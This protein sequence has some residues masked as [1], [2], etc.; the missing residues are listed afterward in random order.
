MQ[1]K[2]REEDRIWYEILEKTKNEY[3]IDYQPCVGVT[4][5]RSTAEKLLS[6][7]AIRQTHREKDGNLFWEGL[8]GRELVEYDLI[9]GWLLPQV[10]DEEKRAQ[11]E[12]RMRVIRREGPYDYPE[13]FGPYS[14]PVK[15]PS[16]TMDYCEKAGNGIF[17]V[18]DGKHWAWAIHNMVV[19]TD[20]FDT[21]FNSTGVECEEFM[22]FYNDM[23]SLATYNL[24]VNVPEAVEKYLVSIEALVIYLNQKCRARMEEFNS[25]VQSFASALEN[26][27]KKNMI[28]KEYAKVNHIPR[29]ELPDTQTQYFLFP[30]LEVNPA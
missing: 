18:Y 14:P 1:N 15:T 23:F 9:K 3:P 20:M 16:G 30:S 7:A 11:L 25:C 4:I 21:Y 28:L 19:E 22:F 6:E 5:T 8:I 2:L 17:L 27:S 10:T 24:Y 26:K 12:E 29:V 13:Y